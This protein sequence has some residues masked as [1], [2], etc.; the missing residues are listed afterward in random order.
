MTN[1][2]WK[3]PYFKSTIAELEKLVEANRGNR[4]TLSAVARELTH[5]DTDRAGRLRKKV[6]S[7]LKGEELPLPKPTG[8]PPAPLQIPLRTRDA[9]NETPSSADQVTSIEQPQE[10]MPVDSGLARRPTPSEP[11]SLTKVEE[12]MLA[13]ID[14]VIAVEKDKLKPITDVAEHKG[15][16][17]ASH[18][19]L[20]LPGV[21]LNR[22]DG[23]D[24]AWLRVERL[25]KALPPQPADPSLAIWINLPDD[26]DRRPTLRGC[27]QAQDLIDLG[28]DT[29]GS[30]VE[31]DHF[32]GAESLRLALAAYVE[33]P[34]TDWSV[35]EITRRASISLYNQLFAL[36]QMMT[37]V[38]G[39]PIELVCGIGYA[40]L[41]RGRRLRYPLLTVPME[42]DLDDRSQAILLRPRLEARPNVEADPLDIME[43][44]DVEGWRKAA[45]ASIEA[46]EDDPL[47]PFAPDTYEA[48]LQRAVSLLDPSASYVRCAD[49]QAPAPGSE[50]IITDAFGFFQRE[51]RATQLMDDLR[52]YRGM[53]AEPDREASIPPGIAAFFTE[54]SSEPPNENFPLYR[55]VSSIAGVTSNDGSGHDLY[56]PK[57]FNA[58]Q[59]QIV[60]R[61]AV[62]DGVVVQGPPGTGKTHTIANIIS[63][64]LA[65]GKRV[66][67]TSQKSPALKVLREQ[68]PAA[69]RPL[70]V[71]LLDS[72]REGLKQFQ[73]S[74]DTISE[75]L[76][77][78]RREDLQRQ[79][80]AL[81][82]RIDKLHR[83]L[84][85][86]D[87]EVEAVGRSA[88]CP[89]TL[90]GKQIHPLDAAGEVAAALE[91]ATW[92]VDALD[93]RPE[94][95]ALLSDEDYGRL[96]QARQAVGADLS[97][98]GAQLP[99]VSLISN[100]AKLARAHVDLVAA[101][102]IQSE[103]E[104]GDVLPLCDTRPH[105][106]EQVEEVANRLGLWGEA[107]RKLTDESPE[108]MRALWSAQP[109]TSDPVLVALKQLREEAESVE[110]EH[111]HFISCPVDLPDDW[112]EDPK[113][114][115]CVEARAQGRNGL[116]LGGLFAGKTKA[117]VAAIRIRGEVPT[118]AQD[119]A[120]V[121]RF[122][123]ASARAARLA[124][125]WNHA[126]AGH[127][128]P[129][130]PTNSL[131]AGR[132]AASALR[133]VIHLQA[134]SLEAEALVRSAREL[135]PAWQG[136]IDVGTERDALLQNL[137]KHL[138]RAGLV[139]AQA[140]KEEALPALRGKTHDLAVE[141]T[142][143]FQVTLGN[144]EISE[145]EFQ[146][147]LKAL[148][149]RL[150]DLHDLAPEFTEIER[151][152]GLLTS[153]G[154]PVW[155]R[156]L[157]T[158]PAGYADALMP[159]DWR[160]RW[161]R[162]RLL[163]ILER[164]DQHGRLRSLYRERAQI[165]ADMRRAY[166][167][168]IEART[169]LELK[170]Q[171]S[172]SVL[173]ALAEY[174]RAVGKIGR[175]T[176]KSANRHRKAARVAANRAKGALPCWIMPHYRVSESLPPE[177]GTFDLVIVDEA[178]Q[179]TIA[180]LPALFRA[181]QILVVGDDKQV[182]P[183]VVG[184]EMARADALAQRHLGEQV[185]LHANAMRE[186]SSLYDLAGVIF[187]A[188]KLMLQE[189]FRCAAPLIEFSKRQFYRN[190][191]RPL[192]LSKASERLDPP[193]IDI[194]VRDGYRK[195]KVNPP[196][197]DCIIDQLRQISSDPSLVGRSVGVTTLLG[198]EQAALI[199]QK[200]ENELGIEF[201][202]RFN[203]RVG[204][205]TV[206][207]G[208]ERDIMFLS[209]V[210]APGDAAALSGLAYEQ[211]FNVAASRARERMVLVRSVDLEHLSPRDGLR[212]ALLEH[213]RSPFPQDT[214]S[215]SEAR[216][217]CESD[218][219][220]EMFDVLDQRGYCVQ[221]QV[222]V[223]S[224]RID[225]VVEGEDDRRLAVECDGDRYHGPE[226]WPHDMQRQRTL[227][228]AG[229][230][231]WRC[232]ASRFVRERD[233]VIEELL[234]EL[235]ALAIEPRS[236]SERSSVYTAALEWRSND[237]EPSEIEFAG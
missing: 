68:L 225:L 199:F 120:D 145:S 63:H 172:A 231:V 216:E 5:R 127:H 213:F 19:L 36:K 162:R 15:F 83:N 153:N 191:L 82:L 187:G 166:E 211:R 176:G 65:S 155:A 22:V 118:T 198:T 123:E 229:W 230:I 64:Y 6:A 163:T 75:R 74:V 111:S 144:P 143:F 60:Q 152:T 90:D 24:V 50:L 77:R 107:H 95:D 78:E 137:R 132:E 31:L 16:H 139:E 101:A 157:R 103:I 28:E 134:M 161:H 79:I 29:S 40:T 18:E 119:W 220:R 47:S 169:W 219:E 104:R 33:G 165:E 237:A 43:L 186:E 204:D 159:Q 49:K 179:S 206:F 105:T 154:A 21:A 20:S 26:P 99:S 223:G 81:D 56:F 34:W 180:A 150:Q 3:D 61:L 42:I 124:S 11:R 9:P 140:L 39:T 32:E 85:E 67:V 76:Q 97:Y 200:V 235:Q 201:M 72:D 70:A 142:E 121:A 146:R 133:Q 131:R 27:V 202:E 130:V 228:R 89:I 167:Q 106:F 138:R 69:V 109:I 115:E 208:D 205:P 181:Q 207:Q 14:Y 30:R 58:E 151:I 196:E 188:D 10:N 215:Q 94:H 233:H 185:A 96:R 175:G 93:E 135:M 182:S 203:L 38:D 210:A 160:G 13:L 35:K 52:A 136:R 214:A 87:R 51:R 193:L 100:Q 88:L 41:L 149:D 192:R 197:A 190:E 183:D 17:R 112:R 221:T 23:D 12:R 91:E 236:A 86:V 59:A 234:G 44:S 194:F 148:V 184:R 126:V 80:D 54:P 113:L 62:R 222:R 110:A 102:Q 108:W 125:S 168:A 25:G 45:Q 73:A 53:I 177:F 226:Q 227:E 218:F 217:R 98:L 116:T 1:K 4:A 37:V 164:S 170:K 117:R 84:A 174:A 46:L 129:I 122:M 224:Y 71:S 212:R 173:T 158:E 195:G 156:R 55:G 92:F 171:A 7:L 178:S 189:H 2:R 66:L 128:V 141:F 114:R 57:P 8:S 48:V 209:L 232:F 147:R